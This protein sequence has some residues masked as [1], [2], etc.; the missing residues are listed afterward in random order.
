MRRYHRPTIP[1]T[2]EVFPRIC[3]QSGLPIQTHP[4]WVYT[5]PN[6]TYRTTIA[7][8]GANIFWVIP[9]GY[10]TDEDMQ[11]AVALAAAILPE[12]IY[13]NAPF[14]FIENF[15]GVHGGTAGARRLYLRYTN[16]LK[17]LLG[18]F[19]YGMPPFF[20]L[21][22][23]F[24]RRLRL[25][26]YR[27]HM[28]AHYK[29][30]VASAM[31]LLA[32][33]GMASPLSIPASR[34]RP[35]P[36]NVR[37]G[38]PL[39][40]RPVDAIVPKGGLTRH[41]DDLLAYLGKLDL[42]SRG[43]PAPPRHVQASPM[44]PVYET[45]AMLK[46][47]MDQFLTEHRDLVGILRE[48]RKEL[49]RK[50]TVIET[51]NKELQTLLQRSHAR[52]KELGN[53]VLKNMQTL[54]KPIL[55]MIEGELQRADQRGWIQGMNT[56]LDDLATDFSVPADFECYKL[57]PQEIRVAR[58]VREG[59]STQTIARQLG[60]SVRTIDY[61]RGRLREKLGIKGRRRNLRTALLA[62]PVD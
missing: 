16:S 37:N 10:V 32:Q 25:H 2:P 56:H 22:F 55:G 48:R 43:I 42:E 39:T 57:T 14:V 54:L 26:R 41:V 38:D 50:T 33:H 49:L 12:I 52:Q 23:N 6:H 47:D 46:L 45:L 24:S 19:P 17:G 31:A 20:R 29:D 11:Q 58:L 18:S 51:R 7:L 60:V 5:N 53:I 13:D 35:A 62:I 59:V 3:P 21:S 34:K 30:A 40:D 9:R 4:D 61:Y 27:V 28:V 8:I 44:A 15:A 36:S 1:E